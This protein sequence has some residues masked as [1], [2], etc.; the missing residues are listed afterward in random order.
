MK[1]WKIGTLI[2]C[3][4][5]LAVPALAADPQKNSTTRAKAP[6][7]EEKGVPSFAFDQKAYMEQMGKAFGSLDKNGD[8]KVDQNELLHGTEIGEYD[9][10]DYT[11]DFAAFQQP[12]TDATVTEPEPKT[13]TAP[14]AAIDASAT[15]VP[16]VNAGQLLK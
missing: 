2:T 11:D 9:E 16:P 10:S 7:K 12:Q 8:G 13:T 3:A 6:P 1:I 14:P 15:G 5:L 4:C